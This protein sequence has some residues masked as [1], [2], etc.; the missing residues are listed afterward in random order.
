MFLRKP[1]RPQDG[2]AEAGSA[3]ATEEF[4]CRLFS[5]EEENASLKRVAEL[6]LPREVESLKH[7][8]RAEEACGELHFIQ[9]AEHHTAFSMERAF[10]VLLRFFRIHVIYLKIR[11]L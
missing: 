9:S 10:I 11:Q 4:R 8:V 5:L 7:Q 6:E 1:T 3:E 2:R